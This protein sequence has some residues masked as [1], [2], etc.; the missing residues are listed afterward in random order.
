MPVRAALRL[1]TERAAVRPASALSGGRAQTV[2]PARRRLRLRGADDHRRRSCGPAGLGAGAAASDTA[3]RVA[4]P[5]ASLHRGRQLLDA[6]LACGPTAVNHRGLAAAARW[7]GSSDCG[8]VAQCAVAAIGLADDLWSGVERGFRAHLGGRP[9]DRRA[10]AGRHSA[11]R[12]RGLTEAL[13]RVARRRSAANS[14]NQLDT[15]PGRALKAYLLAAPASPAHR[16]GPPS[17]SRLTISARWRC[18]E[19]PA[20][21]ALGAML[22]LSS[23]S[24]LTDEAVGSRS[25][26]SRRPHPLGET[27]SLGELI[28]RTPVLYAARSRSGGNRS[29]P[30]AEVRLRHRRRRLVPRQGHHLPPR[31]AGC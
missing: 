15:R 22:G 4:T 1:R 5:P 18:S 23:V 25:A 3:P 17:S 24:R 16:L 8:A 2:L 10:Q 19:T 6:L 21:N 9:H 26:P 13:G 31:S 14:L 29:R 30:S 12:P 20:A 27:R 7:A 28:E 11:R